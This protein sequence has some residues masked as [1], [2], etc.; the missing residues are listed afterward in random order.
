MPAFDAT[1][2]QGMGPGT[3]WGRG[4]CGGGRAWRRGFGSR[5][6]FGMGGGWGRGF[7][8]YSYRQPTREEEL[9]NLEEE[10]KV[11]EEDLKSVQEEITGL[12]KEK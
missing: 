4:P 8:G 2:P 3:G 11:L 12:K 9:G 1:G 5:R 10:K 6:G 7:G